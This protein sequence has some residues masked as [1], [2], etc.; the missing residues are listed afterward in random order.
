LNA[1]VSSKNGKISVKS[2]SF[3]QGP[4]AVATVVPVVR[5]IPGGNVF[6]VDS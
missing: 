3:R 4:F 2:P 1:S 5:V 6:F